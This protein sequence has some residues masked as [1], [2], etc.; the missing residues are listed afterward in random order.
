LDSLIVKAN[1]IGE[2]EIEKKIEAI[3]KIA[4]YLVNLSV[5]FRRSVFQQ[6]RNQKLTLIIILMFYVNYVFR[7]LM[8]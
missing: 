6:R 1:L 7:L 8:L 4:C 3:K 2:S 5:G